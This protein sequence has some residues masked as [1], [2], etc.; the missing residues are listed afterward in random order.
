MSAF[1]TMQTHPSYAEL[2]C[3]LSKYPSSAG[4]LFQT[5]NDITLAQKWTNIEL[6]DLPDCQRAAVKGLRPSSDSVELPS[7]CVVLPCAL[8]EPISTSYFGA[9]FTSLGERAPKE[10]YLAICAE[11]SSIV[12]YKIS[13]GI[14][15]PSI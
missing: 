14:V 10:I 12:Y 13:K 5:F 9:A 2:T 4:A 8:A 11:D 7:T 6:V 1:T 15:K 3:Y